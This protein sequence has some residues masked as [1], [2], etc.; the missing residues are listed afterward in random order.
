MTSVKASS[1]IEKQLAEK[2]YS[3]ILATRSMPAYFNG[4]P[5]LKVSPFA[6]DE[7]YKKTGTILYRYAPF[8]MTEGKYNHGSI[9][10]SENHL[11]IES[12][13]VTI[14]KYL[15]A[16]SVSSYEPSEVI[17][18]EAN[19]KELYVFNY[20]IDE[21]IGKYILMVNNFGQNLFCE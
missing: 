14:D 8:K 7:D 15:F 19:N 6:N 18:T 5:F 1:E 12:D 17:K 11:Q 16:T 21:N 9:D 13:F 20:N 2:E 4:V 10:I 3:L